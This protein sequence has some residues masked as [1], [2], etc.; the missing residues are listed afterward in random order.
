MDASFW[1]ALASGIAVAAACGLR[2]F[3]PLLLLGAAARLGWIELRDG[4]GWLATD[5]ALITLTVATIVEV[6]ADK[7][8]V[9]DHALD[10]VATGLRPAA[11]WLG[12]FAVLQAWPTPWA[13]IAAVVLGT[14]ALAVHAAKAKLRLGS[15]AVSLGAANPFVSVI[16]DVVAFVTLV[17]GVLAPLLAVIMLVLVAVTLRRRPAT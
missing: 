14:T 10:V 3:L 15:T 12:A 16:E 13:Q 4:V 5:L 6:A 2:A 1:L 7:I 17:V 11:A 9:V 8:P